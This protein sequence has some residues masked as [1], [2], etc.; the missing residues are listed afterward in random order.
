MIFSEISIPYRII[1]EAVL[2]AQK[3]SSFLPHPPL[4]GNTVKNKTI[5]TREYATEY[6]AKEYPPTSTKK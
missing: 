4:F 1:L 5:L 6:S 2:E 3:A